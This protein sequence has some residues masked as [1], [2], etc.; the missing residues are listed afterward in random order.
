[1]PHHSIPQ[2]PPST[3]ANVDF[4]TE[5]P[6]IAVRFFRKVRKSDTGCWKWTGAQG[7]HGYGRFYINDHPSGRTSHAAHRVSY[8]M[9]KGAI[10][11]GLVIDHLCNNP[12]CVNPDHLE[13]KTNRENIIRGKGELMRIHRTGICRRGHARTPETIY[14]DRH[15]R[16]CA[17]DGERDRARKRSGFVPGTVIPCEECSAPVMALRKTRRF[18]SRDCQKANRARTVAESRREPA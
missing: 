18:C 2:E 7:K 13:S 10:P 17:A 11:S 6:A 5:R 8:E 16:Q 1:M 4:Y 15:C 14:G 12:S 9:H 3:S